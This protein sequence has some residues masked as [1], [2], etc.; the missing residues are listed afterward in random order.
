[1]FAMMD[2]C[3]PDSNRIVTDFLGRPAG[4]PAGLLKLARRF[5]Y[6]AQLLS[7]RDGQP[8]VLDAFAPADFDV[9]T[10]VKRINAVI[11]KEILRDPPRWLLW[12]L[13]GDRW[14]VETTG[15]TEVS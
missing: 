7:Q 4:A 10:C 15:P 6:E 8:L 2:H 5:G 11:E 13:A 9:V 1:M 12:A 14:E 3:Y